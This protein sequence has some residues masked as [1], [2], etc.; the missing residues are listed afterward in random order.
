M[1]SGSGQRIGAADRAVTWW[2]WADSTTG[3][4]YAIVAGA[5]GASFVDVTVPGNPLYMSTLPN[6]TGTS[7]WRGNIS[8]TGMR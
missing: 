5:N 4:E 2:R 8:A 7:S 1:G 3:K 6:A